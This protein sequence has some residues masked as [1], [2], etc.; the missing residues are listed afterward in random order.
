VI[1]RPLILTEDLFDNLLADLDRREAAL[2]LHSL[3]KEPAVRKLLPALIGLPW[4]MVLSEV[5]DPGLFKTLATQAEAADPMTRKRGFIQIVDSEP[6]RVELPPRCL[7]IYLL[8]GREGSAQGDFQSRLRRITMLEELRRSGARQTLIVSGDDNPVP[9]EM[10]DLWSS[11][12]RSFLTFATDAADAKSAL[13]IWASGVVGFTA[14]SLLRLPAGQIIANIVERYAAIYPE[15]RLII[16]LR[17]RGGTVKTVDVTELDDPERPLLDQY[18]L[19]EERHLTTLTPDQL[20]EEEFVS[21]FQNPENS[22]RP[23]AAGL[24]WER[25]DHSK[26]Q[27]GAVLK[28]LDAVGPEENCVAYVVAEPGAGGT[29]FTRM[30]AWEYAREGYPVLIA[31]QLPFVPDALSVANFLNRVRNGIRR[32]RKAD[33]VVQG[34]H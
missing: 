5:S 16:R 3:P 30:L 27:F 31:K 25:H 29:T 10:K 15:E 8:N 9:P 26:R 34:K 23:Y 17:D 21:F 4:R 32:L 13:D 19:I 11:G 24:P 20:S 6:S 2:W 1:E 22:W 18:S 7:P 12:F 14:A 33:C 28:K